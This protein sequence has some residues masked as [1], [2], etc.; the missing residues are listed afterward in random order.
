MDLRSSASNRGLC[1]PYSGITRKGDF[2][3]WDSESK[4]YLNIV[5]NQAF[6]CGLCGCSLFVVFSYDI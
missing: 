5:S 1:M 4:N 6:L 3:V 2:C